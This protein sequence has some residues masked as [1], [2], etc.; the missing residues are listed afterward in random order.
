MKKQIN[1]L[2]LNKITVNQLEK[3]S[4]VKGGSTPIF[5][6]TITLSAITTSVVGW[7]SR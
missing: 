7:Y 6:V 2:D 3:S 5:I 4:D 1:R